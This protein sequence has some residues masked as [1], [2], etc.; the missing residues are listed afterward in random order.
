[1]IVKPENV[2][3]AFFDANV[4]FSHLFQLKNIIGE[5]VKFRHNTGFPPARLTD[6]T[7]GTDL[8]GK[9]AKHHV[10]MRKTDSTDITPY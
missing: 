5:D 7:D 9:V 2:F 4:N 3:H 6:T 8:T 10:M 1:M